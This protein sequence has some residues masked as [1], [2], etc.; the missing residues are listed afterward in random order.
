MLFKPPGLLLGEGGLEIP[1]QPPETEKSDSPQGTGDCGQTKGNEGQEGPPT[2]TVKDCRLLDQRPIIIPRTNE[3]F[4]F[5]SL[6]LVF[7]ARQTQV[8]RAASPGAGDPVWH[9]QLPLQA[10][11]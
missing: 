2:S 1:A 6:R 3:C 4:L 5:L 9:P 10:A 8:R 7:T 11:T